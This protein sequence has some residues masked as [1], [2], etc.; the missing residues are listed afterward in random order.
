[1][2]SASHYVA[3]LSALSPTSFAAQQ[4]TTTAAALAT[5]AQIKEKTNQLQ[6]VLARRVSQDPLFVSKLIDAISPRQQ[7]RHHAH[8]QQTQQCGLHS[9]QQPH[10]SQVGNLFSG[11]VPVAAA[12]RHDLL[13]NPFIPFPTFSDTPS[14]EEQ[15]QHQRLQSRQLIRNE[16]EISV[17][18]QWAVKKITMIMINEL[19]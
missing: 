12:R 19:K 3:V 8:E 10:S 14:A 5:Q 11:Q 4:V 15:H 13:S 6:E 9:L 1:M 7:P 2:S 18:G 17:D 16:P